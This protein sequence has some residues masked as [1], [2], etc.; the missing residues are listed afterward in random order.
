MSRLRRGYSNQDVDC[1]V[2][3]GWDVVRICEM[4]GYVIVPSMFRDHRASRSESFSWRHLPPPS[5][6]PLLRADNQGFQPAL[7][8]F[9]PLRLLL[10]SVLSI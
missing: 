8:R 9:S 10:D 7:S 3:G 6:S 5:L 4:C 2:R 1:V